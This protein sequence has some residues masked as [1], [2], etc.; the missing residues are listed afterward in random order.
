MTFV[1]LACGG[2]PALPNIPAYTTNVTQTPYNAQGDGT[3][4][5]TTAIQTAIN[6]VASRGGGTVEIP[7]PGVYL[8]GPLTL[9]NKIN[10]QIDGGATLRM[11]PYTNWLGSTPLLT[12]SSL[13]NVE[14]SGSGGIDG[15][16][17]DWWVNKP[18]SGLYMIY[19]NNCNT[20]LVQ[21]VAVSNAPAQQIVFKGK[22]GN[23]TI[24][25]VTILA[26][27]S[28]AASPSHNTDGI[29]LVGT[30]CLVQNCDISTGDDNIAIGSSGGVSAGIL[31]T[32]C[33]FGEGHGM[34]IGSYTSGGVSNLIVINCTFTNTD[35][36]IRMKSDNDR[37]GVV[38]N[39]SYFNLNMT[40]VQMPFVIYSYYNNAY[41][42]NT[43][44]AAQ[45]ASTNA[46]TVTSTT[47]IWRNVIIS[48]V[49]AVAASGYPAGTIWARVEMPATNFVF[50]HINVTASQTFNVFSG[51]GIQF[52][53]SQISVPSGVKT[54]TLYNA[55]LVVSNSAPSA[56]PVTLDGLTTNGFGNG[57]A[58][59]NTP[60]SLSNTNV[61]G[62]AL[63][64]LSGSTL[65]VSNDFQMA[66]SSAVS[67]TLGTNA[68][69][70]V[71]TSNLLV[72]G[73]INITPGAGFTNGSYT[74]FTYGRGLGWGPPTLGSTP[75]VYAY[76]FDTN[77]TGQIS[78]LVSSTNSSF[79]PAITNQPANLTVLAGSNALFTVGT[80]GST[81]LSYQWWFNT[82]N[83]V[84]QGTNTSLT[85]SNAQP[86][87]AGG[88]SVIVTNAAGNATSSVAMLKVFTT[89][90]ATLV[91]PAASSNGQ[92]SFGATGVTGFN[93][94]VQASTNLVD[95]RGLLTNTAPFTF[96]DANTPLFPSRF[97]RAVYLP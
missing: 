89:A 17:A 84:A 61:L 91:S 59:Y 77:T 13:S 81:P 23:I 95:W 96:T 28:H 68:A 65:T 39:L 38:Q 69:K 19:F 10:L 6:D 67:F 72:S 11:K 73:T 58:L 37:G 40:K 35:N 62:N 3:N 34:S 27:S 22:A 93:Y 46:A 2:T 4:D 79:P 16:G 80:S 25:G 66:A 20:V 60:C 43:I 24:Q 87:D 8:S 49:T 12:F 48:N 92:F 14:L 45:A 41:S 9:Q 42:P 75:A 78:L 70:L 71:V 54:F 88:Y 21:N 44:T 83:S 29:D 86:A 5:D 57:V 76:A 26:P 32:N 30:N 52:L 36:G 31:V 50:S 51:C 1:G 56:N 55:Q 82:T 94:A 15:Q 18:G 90:A 97:Y 74:L 85:V 47:P 63:V 33:A 64:T 7:G 53:D